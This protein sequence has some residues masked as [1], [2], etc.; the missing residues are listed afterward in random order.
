MTES[1]RVSV[2]IPTKNRAADL[3][4][5]VS[6]IF[7]QTFAP[8]ALVIVDQSPNDDGRRVVERAL[9]EAEALRGGGWKL[10]YVLDPTI[11]GASA[12]RNHA[13]RIADGDIWLFLDDDVVLE[14]LIFPVEFH[15]QLAT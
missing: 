13:M 14:G 1:P 11:A 5:V 3:Q 9:A 7:A 2:I 8:L 12:A 10:N 4:S 15:D 6:S